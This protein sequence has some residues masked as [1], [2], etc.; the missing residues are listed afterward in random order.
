MYIFRGTTNLQ[1]LLSASC[2]RPRRERGSPTRDGKTP[3]AREPQKG[4][5]VQ[6]QPQFEAPCT[7]NNDEIGFNLIVG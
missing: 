7:K 1:I 3:P 2:G 5:T 6:T 4:V